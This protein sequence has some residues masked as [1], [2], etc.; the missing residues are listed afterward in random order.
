MFQAGIPDE[1]WPSST[2]SGER[3]N[4]CLEL[5]SIQNLPENRLPCSLPSQFSRS[6]ED[7]LQTAYTIG[8][9]VQ[10]NYEVI[11]GRVEDLTHSLPTYKR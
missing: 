9:S 3:K 5:G 1:E 8:G 11:H 10:R 6:A 7:F 2:A 4:G